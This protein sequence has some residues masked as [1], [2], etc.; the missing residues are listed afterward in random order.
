MKLGVIG[1]GKMGSAI[2]RGVVAAGLA[3]EGDIY[4]YDVNDSVVAKAVSEGHSS[5]ENI[6]AVFRSCD[7]VLFAVKPQE[8]AALIASVL[9]L[10]SCKLILSIMAG[11]PF[12]AF[13]RFGEV[14]M[15][16]VMPNTC[17]VI[18]ESASAICYNQF[19]T[20][21]AVTL[22][23]EICGAIGEYVEIDES[24]MDDVIPAGGSFTAYAYL[25]MKAFIDSSVKRGIERETA[26]KLVI[27][28][29]IGSAKMVERFDD[30]DKLIKD[31]CSKG[32]TT[33][34]GLEK[35][36]DGGFETMIDDCCIAC[37][38]RSKE[39]GKLVTKD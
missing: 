34:A 30:T 39:L 2:V 8:A 4:V 20:P 17:A 10:G 36:Y 15:A 35:L 37:A 28:S 14:A 32:G 27:Q 9:N 18:G 13:A 12:S 26:K 22:T 25:F 33:L 7:T 23:R 5:C 21:G 3:K 29:M 1:Y 6:N 24:L 16:C 11:V 19:V 31:V 38:E